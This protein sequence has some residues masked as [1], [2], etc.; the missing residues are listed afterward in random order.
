[1]PRMR[2]P[3][4]TEAA[5]PSEDSPD[6]EIVAG[7]NRAYDVAPET[8]HRDAEVLDNEEADDHNDRRLRSDQ[9]HQEKGDDGDI[10]DDV[11]PS[12]A[13]TMPQDRYQLEAVRWRHNAPGLVIHLPQG[14]VTKDLV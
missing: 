7:A 5:S 11:R 3:C 14:V 8:P 2:W 12:G 1:M 13:Q 6:P 10:A 4:R 9:R